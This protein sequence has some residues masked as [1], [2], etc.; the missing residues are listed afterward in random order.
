MTFC[1]KDL[2]ST[3]AGHEVKVA[4]GTSELPFEQDFV[5]WCS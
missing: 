1:D 2:L 5:E 4:A 3:W